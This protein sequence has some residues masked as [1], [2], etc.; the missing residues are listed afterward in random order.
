MDSGGI[1]P[2]SAM[3][4]RMYNETEWNEGNMNGDEQRDV[5]R[6][7]RFGLFEG[8]FADGELRREG[9][10][11]KLQDQPFRLL[12]RLL[13]S[14]GAIVTREELRAALWPDGSFVD[15][16]YGVSTA[17]KKVRYALGDSADNPRF[18]QTLP[19]KGYRFLAPVTREGTLRPT[20]A[21]PSVNAPPKRRRIWI[22]AAAL[23][24][25]AASGSGSFT[26]G[27]RPGRPAFRFRSPPT[28]ARNGAQPS[29]PMA[30]RSRSR[31]TARAKTT[32]T[33]TSRRTARTPPPASRRTPRQTSVRRGHPTAAGSPFCVTS[34]EAVSAL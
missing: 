7:A 30:A 31:G 12:A 5:P 24:A 18:I 19:R 25:I 9:T 11:V 15:F 27:P 3:N 10:L 17:I 6:I 23:V 16:D 33:F 32:T 34:A 28:R 20:G 2:G 4:I 1:L 21:S 13:E 26:G 29:L 22:I 8:D 14:P